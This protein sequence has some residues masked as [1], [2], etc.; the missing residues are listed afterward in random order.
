MLAEIIVCFFLF[1][2]AWFVI[3]SVEKRVKVLE[4][5]VVRRQDI[6][7]FKPIEVRTEGTQ[8]K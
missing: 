1:A 5:I 6:A 4:D 2:I 7:R 3:D 8:K